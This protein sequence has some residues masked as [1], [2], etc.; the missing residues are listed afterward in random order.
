MSGPE[1]EPDVAWAV[2]VC[3][4]GWRG[5]PCRTGEEIA[6]EPA[7]CP[8]C[9]GDLGAEILKGSWRTFTRS[10]VAALRE[11]RSE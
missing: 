7:E 2:A 3:V 4:C 10:R 9:G 1:P 11:R 8:R 5:A 6:G